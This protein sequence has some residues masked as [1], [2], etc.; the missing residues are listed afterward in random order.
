MSTVSKVGPRRTVHIAIDQP[1]D[2]A[3]AQD[4]YLNPLT[5]KLIPSTEVYFG[6]RLYF[7]V[8]T[9]GGK[10]AE[11]DPTC[12]TVGFF[13]DSV[14]QCAGPLD[15]FI[16]HLGIPGLQSYNGGIQGSVLSAT[17]DRAL[18]VSA[19]VDFKAVVVHPG[20]HNLIYNQTTEAYWRSQFQRLDISSPI[21]LMTL[22]MDYYPGVLDRGYG[23]LFD[24]SSGDLEDPRYYTRIGSL[25]YTD[26]AL[27]AFVDAA[28]RMN[29]F[30][31]AYA[32]EKGHLIIDLG[33]TVR[34]KAYGDLKRYF[35]DLVHLRPIAYPVMGPEI[36]RQLAPVLGAVPGGSTSSPAPPQTQGAL[37]RESGPKP[38]AGQNYP[39]W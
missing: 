39:L 5:K 4:S 30:L 26:S 19:Q 12:P 3:S 25:D 34:P 10:G 8:N 33:Q 2:Y 32:A 22:D 36:A 17:I 20:W 31:R 16:H 9:L 15:S 13:G 14:V 1:F 18:E 7:R 27:T 38:V 6:D 21:A 24:E 28:E 29:N 23:A 35:W 37:N 11:I